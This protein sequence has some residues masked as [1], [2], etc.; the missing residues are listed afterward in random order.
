MRKIDELSKPK[1]CM[2][3]AHPQ[4]MVFV[5]LGR[6][7]AAPVAIRAWV[8]ERIRVGK[9]VETDEKIVE[10]LKC[11]STMEEEGDRWKQDQARKDQ[12]DMWE[13]HDAPLIA[14][15]RW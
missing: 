3:S 9:N 1:T 11:A 12:L 6:D 8:A 14:G 13:A 5:L 10:A 4:E 7:P 2:Q 15:D